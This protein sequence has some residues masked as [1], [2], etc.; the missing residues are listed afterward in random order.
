MGVQSLTKIKGLYG[1]D[2]KVEFTDLPRGPICSRPLLSALPLPPCQMRHFQAGASH[3]AGSS[4]P[5]LPILSRVPNA[6]G[7]IHVVFCS[8][9]VSSSDSKGVHFLFHPKKKILKHSLRPKH[10]PRC[11][12]HLGFV[13]DIQSIFV[14][15]ELRGFSAKM[16][17]LSGKQEGWSPNCS[18]D[19]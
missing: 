19:K 7:G 14:C 4:G 3:S 11:D 6:L 17:P 16:R 13:R 12:R 2:V 8:Q 9:I 18:L 5:G 15:Q 1:K 10:L